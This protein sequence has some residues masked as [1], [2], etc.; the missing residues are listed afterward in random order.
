[1]L[2][3]EEEF[4]LIERW[5]KDRDQEAFERLL[6]EQ[7]SLIEVLVWRF[8]GYGD[9][10]PDRAMENDDLRQEARIGLLDAIRTYDPTRGARLWT[11]AHWRIRGVFTRIRRIR[12]R[13][14]GR[15]SLDGLSS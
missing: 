5:R 1:M 14:L 4:E 7:R 10:S 15:V 8:S 11:H 13:Q 3:P 12:S 6:E 9:N 2:T